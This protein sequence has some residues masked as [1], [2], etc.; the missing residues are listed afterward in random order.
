MAD[1][2]VLSW[3][4]ENTLRNH[5]FTQFVDLAGFI[6][7]ASFVQFDGFKPVLN[8]VQVANSSMEL[9]VQFDY[10]EHLV[11]VEK[12]SLESSSSFPLRMHATDRAG[13][14]VRYLGCIV[15][16][17]SARDV[18]ERFV[19]QKLILAAT[20]CTSLTRSIP[21]KDAV[22]SFDS[23]FGD[24]SLSRTVS[25]HCLFYNINSS[26]NSLTYNAVSNHRY[27]PSRRVTALKQL[28]LVKPVNNNIFIAS[29]DVVKVE[30]VGGAA[31]NISLVTST[32]PGQSLLP[33]TLA[34]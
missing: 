33:T 11:T 29:N 3:Q 10:G 13:D 16:G 5:P 25:D 27:D 23:M 12:S 26:Y 15:F 34:I 28:N 17:A 14:N 7:D 31:I 8:Y 24:V 20:F 4:N 1:T 21:S 6:V 19:G 18:F 9:S 22:Y 2:T 30:P 32:A